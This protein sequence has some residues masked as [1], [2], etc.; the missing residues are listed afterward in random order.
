MELVTKNVCMAACML[1]CLW[2]GCFIKNGKNSGSAD[3]TKVR[4]SV[5]LLSNLGKC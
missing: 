4:S 2:C 3:R 5:S 1:L